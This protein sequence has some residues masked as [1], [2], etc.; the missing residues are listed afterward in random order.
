MMKE[1]KPTEDE[2]TES[3]SGRDMEYTTGPSRVGQLVDFLYRTGLLKGQGPF[4]EGPVLPRSARASGEL[5]GEGRPLPQA[6]KPLGGGGGA[7]TGRA[8]KLAAPTGIVG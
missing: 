8:Q 1:K 4:L 3:F 6:A 2:L 7:R 5:S